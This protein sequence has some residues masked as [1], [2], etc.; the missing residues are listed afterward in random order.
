MNACPVPMYIPM[1]I[2]RYIVVGTVYAFMDR[3]SFTPRP[4]TSHDDVASLPC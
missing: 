3:H 2:P 1:Y 4:T